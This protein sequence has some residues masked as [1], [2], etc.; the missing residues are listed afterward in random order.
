MEDRK[1][2]HDGHW[3]VFTEKGQVKERCE[4][5][6]TE[7]RTR[8]ATEDGEKTRPAFKAPMVFT[9]G[10]WWRRAT[11]E[12]SPSLVKKIGDELVI[13]AKCEPPSHESQEEWL[14]R[15]AETGFPKITE[16][17]APGSRTYKVITQ[18]DEFFGGKF[19]P[20]LLSNLLTDH[21]AEGWRVVSIA[22]ADVS[23]FFG[24]FWSGRGAR[25][26][27]VIVLEKAW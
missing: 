10:R 26:E 17:P 21:A 5:P 6:T 14:R 8:W 23:T 3:H 19:D 11:G 7:E 15:A 20:L 1:T 24:T 13:N 22:S 16:P 12:T 27:L 25:Q 4:A 18:R 9:D 2:F